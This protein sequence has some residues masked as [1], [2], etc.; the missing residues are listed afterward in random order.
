MGDIEV[1]L[2]TNLINLIAVFTVFLLSVS[3]ATGAENSARH[4][5]S[6][7]YQVY[8]GVVPGNRITKEPY[9]VDRDIS[10]HGGIESLGASDYHVMV[11]IFD[12]NTNARIKDATVIAKIEKKGIMSSDEAVLPMEK[13]ITSGTVTYG[14]FYNLK[15]N[16][17]YEIELKIYRP[18]QSGYEEVEFAYKTY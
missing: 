15:K 5:L 11:A 12:K 7:S 10:L 14:N 17:E 4:A 9:L 3:G 8:L 13:M 6:G 16:T 1:T 18:R 2:R